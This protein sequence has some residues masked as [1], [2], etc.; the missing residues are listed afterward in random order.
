MGN[1]S[2]VKNHLLEPIQASSQINKENLASANEAYLP[3]AR[4]SISN[5][6]MIKQLKPSNMRRNTYIEQGPIFED[7]ERFKS[8]AA[9]KKNTKRHDGQME[10]DPSQARKSVLLTEPTFEFK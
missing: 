3:M 10:M 7:D 5:Q 4:T 8:F 9:I 2:A 6:T 1:N